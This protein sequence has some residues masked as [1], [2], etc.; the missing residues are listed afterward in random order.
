[1]P[2]PGTL[3]DNKYR[4]LN[5]LPV[6]RAYQQQTIATDAGFTLIAGTS[7]YHTLH[8]GTLTTIRNIALNSGVNGSAF[9]ITRTGLGAPA[10]NVAGLITLATGDWAEVVHDGAAWYLAAYG[11]AASGS[12][13][14]GDVVG[15]GGSLLNQITRY[16][17]TTGKLIQSSTA[18][19]GD[20]GLLTSTTINASELRE[21]GV[22]IATTYATLASP[23]LAGTPTTPTASPGTST[24]QIASTAF[25]ATAVAA[26]SGGATT[27]IVDY[28]LTG[29]PIATGDHNTTINCTNAGTVTLTVPASLASGVSGAQF[30]CGIRQGGGGKVTIVAAGGV[31]LRNIDGLFSTENQYARLVLECVATDTYDIIG[32]TGS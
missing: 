5:L 21:G 4:R 18:T 29:R 31:T 15:Q 13:G 20:D 17:S 26:G 27:P 23:H 14:P 22:A 24:T 28:T 7:P 9:L 10:L 30:I 1:V 11:R 6:A 2:S 25:V 32:R 8:T 16:A 3:A 19:I 12:V